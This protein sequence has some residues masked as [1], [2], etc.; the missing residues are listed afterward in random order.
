MS[1]NEVYQN[2]NK[3]LD[4]AKER[5]NI[6]HQ[7]DDGLDYDLLKRLGG[8]VEAFNQVIKWLEQTRFSL[9]N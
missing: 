8:K 9:T 7:K 4:K 5:I 1:I 6:E 3:E 2:I